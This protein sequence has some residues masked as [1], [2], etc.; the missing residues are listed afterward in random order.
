MSNFIDLTG[1]VFDKLKVI[2]RIENHIYP[3][4]LHEVRWKC[5]CECGNIIIASSHNLR[6][7]ATKSCGCLREKCLKEFK[8]QTKGYKKLNSYDLS[9]DF[10][11]GYTAKGEEFYF[12][13]EDYNKIKD[14][15][16]YC[17]YGYIKSGIENKK[18]LLHRLVM[19]PPDDMFVD[20]INHNRFDNRKKNLRIVTQLQNSWNSPKK[21]NN[22]S[23]YSGVYYIKSKKKW[24][25]LIGVNKKKIDL[26]IF[27]NKEDAIKARKE[28]EEKY[29]GEYSYD[30]SMKGDENNEQES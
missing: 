20:H 22:T 11:I 9:G 21:K 29:Y 2:E 25:A 3:S 23:G 5:E 30:N 15:T 14:Y 4:G 1:Q 27:E 6:K 26:G 10:G 16:W 28:A 17:Q 19:C 24:K 18:I 13:L 7:G 12:D 8:G